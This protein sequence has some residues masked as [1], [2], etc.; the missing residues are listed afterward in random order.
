MKILFSVFGII[1]HSRNFVDYM[2]IKK[3]NTKKSDS[4]IIRDELKAYTHRLKISEMG[5]TFPTNRWY[6]KTYTLDNVE[7]LKKNYDDIDNMILK[8]QKKSNTTDNILVKIQKMQQEIELLKVP[9]FVELAEDAVKNNLS[10]VIFVNYRATL[11]ILMKKLNTNCCIHGTL[12]EERYENI[13]L[14]QTDKEQIMICQINSGAT[15]IGLHNVNGG[16]TR[17]GIVSCPLSAKVLLQALGRLPRAGS[18]EHTDKLG[19][20]IP[21]VQ[22]VV[23]I[24]G[25][26]QEERI[27]EIMNSKLECISMINDG[28]LSPYKIQ[29][30]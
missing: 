10:P 8:L 1:P 11:K 15:G 24:A 5:N 17:T 30:K 22:V 13:E 12:G 21:I 28:D 2:K 4:E 25:I 27:A 18:V 19:Q 6:A 26:K 20:I 14:F 3:K 16:R 29:I 9:I 23:F 7:E